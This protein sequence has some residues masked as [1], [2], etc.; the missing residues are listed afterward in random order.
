LLLQSV[1]AILPGTRE[2]L[3]LAHQEDAITKV[4]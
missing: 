1:L 4:V 3:G 2:V